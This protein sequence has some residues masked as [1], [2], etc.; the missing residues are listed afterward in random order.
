M[1]LVDRLGGELPRGAVTVEL[2]DIQATVLRYRP[3]PYYGT[4]VM[5]GV[6]DARAGREFLRRLT[7][8]VASAGDWGRCACLRTRSRVSRTRSGSGWPRAPISSSTMERTT[9]STGTGRSG[10]GAS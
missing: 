5:L 6:D 4:H 8:E 3:E 2:E 9:R 7:P 10:A 1:H